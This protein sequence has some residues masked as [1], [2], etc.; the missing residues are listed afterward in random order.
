[1]AHN[2]YELLKS[3]ANIS[4]NQPF[5]AHT[6]WLKMLE[7]ACPDYPEEAVRKTLTNLVNQGHEGLR[8]ARDV[9][10]QYL[11]SGNERPAILLR[12]IRKGM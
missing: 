10:S 4:K 8:K 2:S 7:G 1:M 9:V 6:I 5:E 3:I 11:K 12:E